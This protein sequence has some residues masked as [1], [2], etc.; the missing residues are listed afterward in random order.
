MLLQETFEAFL[1]VIAQ[2]FIMKSLDNLYS[3]N[4]WNFFKNSFK[5]FLQCYFQR[6]VQSYQEFTYRVLRAISFRDLPS[7]FFKNFLWNS[8][9]NLIRVFSRLPSSIRQR[10]LQSFAQDTHLEISGIFPRKFFQK[11]PQEYL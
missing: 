1:L 2:E 8:K 4:L 5:I 9:E 7:R 10:F 3:K 6:F 11:Y